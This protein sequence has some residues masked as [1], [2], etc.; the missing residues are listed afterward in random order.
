MAYVHH[1]KACRVTEHCL[2][3]A[4]CRDAEVLSLFAAIIAKLREA[5]ADKV[6]VI[7]EAV[8]ECTLQMI[9][10]NFEVR[11]ARALPPAVGQCDACALAPAAGLRTC[12]LFPSSRGCPVCPC[13]VSVHIKK[14]P[15][16]ISGNT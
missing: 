14:A 9:T 10:K 1:R 4:A 13:T 2:S 12:K 7:F 3:L 8:F 11:P 15:C 16:V 5:M 6:P